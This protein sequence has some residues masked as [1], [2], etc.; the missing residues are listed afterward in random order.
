MSAPSEFEIQRALFIWLDGGAL[1]P[2]LIAFHTPN[3]GARSAVEG[4][5]FKQ[6][7][8]KAGIFDVM[9]LGRG[10]FWALELKDHKGALSTAQI[11]MWGR[12]QAAGAAGIGWANSLES[13]KAQIVAWQL[14]IH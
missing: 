1:A 7:G 12:Y 9:I 10:T 3:G 8:V 4:K 11:A 6:A 14:T 13:A 5:R 2:D